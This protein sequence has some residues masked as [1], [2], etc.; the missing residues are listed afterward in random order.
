MKVLGLLLLFTATIE[1]LQSPQGPRRA[2][3]VVDDADSTRRILLASASSALLTMIPSPTL[4]AQPMSPGEADNVGAQLQRRFRPKP[5]KLLRSRLEQDFAVLLM[6]SSYNA[7]DELD[8]VPMEQF[9][10]DFFLLRQAEYETYKNSVDFVQQGDLADPYYFDFISFAQYASINREMSGN[11]PMVFQEQQLV[12]EEQ[13]QSVL[14]RRDPSLTNEMLPSEHDR[15]VGRRILEALDEKF[16]GTPVALPKLSQADRPSPE[17]LLTALTQLVKLFLI[18]GFAW[19]GDARIE[20]RQ[21]GQVQFCLS[22]S[23]PATLWGGK[24]LEFQKATL[25]NDFL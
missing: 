12:G 2:R 16:G 13:F 22:L 6:R 9:Q 11:P 24:A 14:V 23:A 3:S 21:G 4:A 1:A 5:P 17:T 8:C 20:S 10:R 18:N 7:L 25:S 19:D 15:R